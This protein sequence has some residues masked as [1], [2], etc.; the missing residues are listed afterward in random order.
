MSVTVGKMFL[1]APL[2]ATLLFAALLPGPA[3]AAT[4]SASFGVG[5][6]VVAACTVPGIATSAPADRPL[7]PA[8]MCVSD[9]TGMPAQLPVR[10]SQVQTA[11]QS[12]VV[13]EF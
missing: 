7:Q 5:A 3:M 9:K 8:M 4:A 10:V 12:L 2:R 1:P 13:L 11:G 6:E